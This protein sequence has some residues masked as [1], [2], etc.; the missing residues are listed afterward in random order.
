M[1]ITVSFD[2]MLIQELP[3]NVLQHLNEV[4][5]DEIIL[6]VGRL[7]PHRGLW[8]LREVAVRLN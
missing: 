6:H 1:L 7:Q 2:V 8:E 5:L 3:N 4:L